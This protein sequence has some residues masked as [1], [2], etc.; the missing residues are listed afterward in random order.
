MFEFLLGQLSVFWQS[1][2]NFHSTFYEVVRTPKWDTASSC[3]SLLLLTAQGLNIN[4]LVTVILLEKDFNFR[5]N[6]I[7]E[8][9][10]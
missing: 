10:V 4:S 3:F 6:I 8:K 9:L 5:I 1:Y 7:I 2:G